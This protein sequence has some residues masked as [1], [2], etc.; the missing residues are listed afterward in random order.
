MDQAIRNRLR[1]VVTQCRRLL[2]ESIAQQLQGKYDIYATGKKDEVRAEKDVP[3]G[4]LTDEERQAR[5]DIL[6]HF[7]HIKALG[8]KSKETLEQLIREIAFTH[9]N[10]LCAYKMMEVRDVYVGGQKFRE[11]VSKGLKSQGFLFYLADHPEDEQRYNAGQHEE[12]YRHFLNWLGG[13]LSQEIGVLFSPTDP[14]N[15][16]YP[17]QRVLDDV[18]DLLN[19]EDLKG[20]WSE[21]ETIGWVYQYFT[22]KE[23]RDAARDPKRGGSQAPRNSYELAFRNQFF[24]PRFI[25]EFLT[26]NTLGRIWYEMRKGNTRLKDQCR[27][28]VRSPDEVFLADLT[29]DVKSET[30]PPPD[31]AF[32]V[33]KTD[34]LAPFELPEPTVHPAVEQRPGVIQMGWVGYD[35]AGSRLL[36]FAHAVRPFDWGADP[37]M[38][39]LRRQLEE[40]N[41]SEP[42]DRVEGKTQDLWDLLLAVHRSDRFCEGTVASNL[43]ALTRI[44]NEIRRRLLVPKK[45][46][47]N[48]EELTSSPVLIPHRPKKDPREIKILDPACGSG[49]FLLYCFVLLLIIYEEAYDDPD[50][51]PGLQADYP[52]K[53]DL[54]RALPELI[55]RH[56]LHGIDIDLRCTQIA[57]LALWLRCQRAY[58]EMGLKKDRPPITKSNIVC[59]EPMPGEEGLLK[60]F[61]AQIEPKLLGQLVEVVFDKMKLAGEAGSLLKIEEEIRDTVGKARRQWRIGPV[62]TQMRLFGEQKPVERQQRFDLSGINDALF[63]EQAEAKVVDALRSYADGA[64]NGQRLQR[65]LFTDDAEQGFAFVELCH[66]QFDVVLM[67]PPFGDSSKP[68]NGLIEK[69]YL[70]TKN[71]VYAAFVERGLHWL[72]QGGT[73]GAITSRTGFFLSSFQRWREEILL[74]EATPKV[75]AD[76]GYGVLDSAMVE[77]A[78]YCVEARRNYGHASF[79]CLLQADDKEAALRSAVDVANAGVSA[80]GILNVAPGSF[81]QVPGSPFAYWVSDRVR[82]LF[83]ELNAFESGDRTVKQGLA[84]ADDFRF[85]R[86]WWE[87]PP[88]KILDGRK[89]DTWRNDLP[90]FQQW[91]RQRTFE[92]KRWVPFAKGGEFSPFYAD[93]IL[94]VNWERDGEEMKAWAVTLPGTSHWSRRL[95]SNDFYFRPGLTW[96]LRGIRLSAQA[97]PAGG[98]FSIA[99]KLATSNNADE[100]FPLLSLMNSLA[101]DFL[102][103]FFAGKAGGVQY[104]VGLI[105]KV[106]VPDRFDDKQLALLGQEAS[107][108]AAFPSTC[109][110]CRHVFALPRLLTSN[111]SNL[112]ERLNEHQ[113]QL[114]AAQTQLAELQAQ[115]GDLAFRLY[116]IESED[117]GAMEKW[118]L[119]SDTESVDEEPNDSETA[120]VMSALIG[121]QAVREMYL[122]IVG[123]AFGRWDIRF[124]SGQKKPTQLPDP[125]DPLPVCSPGMLQDADGLPLTKVPEGY[126]LRFDDD[127]IL[128]DDPDHPDD[129]IRRVRDVLEVIWKDHADAIEKEACEIL[130]VADLRDYFRKPGAGGFWDDHIK[131]YSKSRRKAPIY[132]LLQSSKKN[133]A[134]WIYYHRLDKDILFKALLHFVEPKIRREESRLDGLRSQKTA[135]GP[136]AK[137]AKKLDKDIDRQDAFLSELREFEE[138]LRRAANLHL[139]PDLN[140]G[141][142][143][144]IAPL[145]EL[146]PWKEAKS[147]LDDLMDGK[148]EWS[149]IG[150]Q[151]REKGLVK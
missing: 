44:A 41:T 39:E 89:G 122:Y 55:L 125:F 51:G 58:Q 61:V 3:L 2:E 25:V 6:A 144:N 65:R 105:G 42:D 98:C 147:Y 111:G 40:W 78:A 70:R 72:H 10:R 1:S 90:K 148:Y 112:A 92:G 142:V 34:D 130:G 97:V 22:P 81:K 19:S 60:E 79:F 24:T 123:C 119:A 57:A 150:K 47:A 15:R 50:L 135:L 103:G 85:V 80:D 20:I 114:E 37:R 17:P 45:E 21:D 84:T 9:L 96:P 108:S 107:R 14:A 83:K 101:F 35:E 68:A 131:R 74:N 77:T 69:Q 124:P 63:F 53:D 27:Y 87:V 95:A 5:Q 59:A 31:L 62:S 113:S 33:G 121:V 129:I 56:N 139:D 126:P 115:L 128:V 104:E 11:S 49:H 28:M 48:Q 120:A 141:V 46:D 26:D 109:D 12:A 91:C 118:S 29:D 99:G 73:L 75:F 67:T 43:I 149:S 110:E 30:D 127:G 66:K 64:Q 71:D 116:G 38:P 140:D 86:C 52:T 93:L 136:A 18:L 117:R 145:R 88:Q 23:L 8:Y 106:P 102:V 146:V 82:R 54:R 132:W 94:V 133:Y 134:L 13:T 76:L 151:L 4:H 143:L 100:L 36:Q 16:V 32:L 7:E 137:G 138:K